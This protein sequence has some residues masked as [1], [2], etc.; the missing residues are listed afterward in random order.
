VSDVD[1]EQRRVIEYAPWAA[2][3][4]EHIRKTFERGA[5][6]EVTASVMYGMVMRGP[7]LRRRP[8]AIQRDIEALPV[9]LHVETLVSKGVKQEAAVKD[10]M[11]AHDCSRR[12]VFKA[13]ATLKRCRS[14]DCNLVHNSV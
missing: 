4:F 7:A 14:S 9:A 1:D 12:H 11:G 13:M 10:A 3:A 8:S 6:D 5:I 2:G